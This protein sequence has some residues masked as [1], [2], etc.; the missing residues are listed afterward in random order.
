MQAPWHSHQ[1]G[2]LHPWDS[3]GGKYPCPAY[4][5]THLKS[6]TWG[7]VC[8]NKHRRTQTHTLHAHIHIHTGTVGEKKN[9]FYILKNEWLGLIELLMF[10]KHRALE[11]EA[12]SSGCQLAEGWRGAQAAVMAEEIMEWN[13]WKTMVLSSVDKGSVKIPLSGGRI[14]D[15]LSYHYL[16]RVMGNWNMKEVKGYW[17]VGTPMKSFCYLSSCSGRTSVG[18][19]FSVTHNSNTFL[20]LPS[21]FR[22]NYVYGSSGPHLE[23]R[24][25]SFLLSRKEKNHIIKW[26]K[27]YITDSILDKEK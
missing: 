7:H 25:I 17:K 10:G 15:S 11:N 22:L 24:D 9:V 26:L 2:Y 27:L 14:L 20:N 21:R 16:H 8:T 6:H 23:G 3:Q 5:S 19:L 18:L 1:A 13:Q 12:V 4:L